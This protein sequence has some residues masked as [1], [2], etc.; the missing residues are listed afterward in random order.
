MTSARL[1]PSLRYTHEIIKLL[2]RAC[3]RPLLEERLLQQLHLIMSHQSQVTHTLSIRGH[4]RKICTDMGVP[5]STWNVLESYPVSPL[6]S[7]DGG[8][9]CKSL[10]CNLHLETFPE[11]YDLYSY[12][13]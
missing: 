13:W 2:N 7:G 9:W 6:G 11:E 8:G 1:T 3:V 5:E 12:P 4:K 10:P